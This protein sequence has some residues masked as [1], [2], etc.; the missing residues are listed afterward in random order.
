M[1]KET[2]QAVRQAELNAAQKEKDAL[3]RKEE[4]LSEARQN[5]SNLIASM[6]KDA[7][8]KAAAKLKAAE[9]E[10]SKMSETAKLKAE[11]EVMIIK[12]M[13][14]RKEDAAINLVL[15]TVINES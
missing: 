5:A 6:T 9:L 1:A 4:I 7:Q 2:V 13:A 8:E 10:S 3:M 11:S 12:E 14:K 15:T